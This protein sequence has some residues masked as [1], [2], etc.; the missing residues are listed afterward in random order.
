MHTIA[1]KEWQL[2]QSNSNACTSLFYSTNA[3]VELFMQMNDNK[4]QDQTKKRCAEI[5][6]SADNT[7]MCN[8]TNHSKET[9]T[10]PINN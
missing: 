2:L 10:K 3:G 1:E 6:A 5:D 9:N 8:K 4:L 7:S